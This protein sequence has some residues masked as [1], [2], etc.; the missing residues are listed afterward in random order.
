MEVKRQF[1]D[2]YARYLSERLTRDSKESAS[3]Y[4]PSVAE[5]LIIV[6]K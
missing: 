1:V 3:I 2:A 4:L 6:R 5:F